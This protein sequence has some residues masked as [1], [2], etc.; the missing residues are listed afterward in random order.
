MRKISV[1]LTG[2][3]RPPI[4]SL[5][6]G[7]PTTCA[8][9]V[10]GMLWHVGVWLVGAA[11]ADCP[12]ALA[13]LARQAGAAG[14]LSLSLLLVYALLRASNPAAVSLGAGACPLLAASLTCA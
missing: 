9:G 10:K 3:V 6:V 14:S 13:C 12:G 5:T 1:S 4:Y 2:P 11:A 8:N 7:A